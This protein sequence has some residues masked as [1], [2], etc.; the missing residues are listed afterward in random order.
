MPK[1]TSET[2]T[3]SYTTAL[4]ALGMLAS[5]M[6]ADTITADALALVPERV[7][8]A[9]AASGTEEIPLPARRCRS[10]APARPRSPPREGALKMREGARVLAEGYDAEFFLHGSAVPLTPGPH[11]RADARA[12]TTAWC[13]AVAEPPD[14]RGHR[15]QPAVE[16]RPRLPPLL[17]ADPA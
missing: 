10:S 6:G 3:V 17:A 13:E 2:Y 12:T 16:S 8:D 5:A 9:L 7:R 11:R 14:G 15:R 1:E 4:L